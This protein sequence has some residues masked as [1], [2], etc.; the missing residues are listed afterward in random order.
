MEHTNWHKDNFH[1]N[2]GEC[3]LYGDHCIVSIRE[4]AHAEALYA[5]TVR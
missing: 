4:A 3:T 1:I 5:N 2:T